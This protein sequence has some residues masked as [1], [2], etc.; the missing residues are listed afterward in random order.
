MYFKSFSVHLNFALKV[1]AI[2]LQ[3]IFLTLN[4]KSR[5]KSGLGFP[6]SNSGQKN[7][8]MRV[9]APSH[10]NTAVRE[11]RGNETEKL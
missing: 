4:R 6:L 1:F 9:S 5:K 7:G 3:A 10:V 11:E 2:E 8:T